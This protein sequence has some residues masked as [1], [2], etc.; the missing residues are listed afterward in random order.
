MKTPILLAGVRQAARFV[1]AGLLAVLIALIIGYLMVL[2]RRPEL[3]PWHTAKLSAEFRSGDLRTVPDLNAY[4]A[5]EEELFRQLKSEVYDQI[6][7]EDRRAFNR[8]SSGSL[9]DPAV[10]A[11]NW[12]RTFILPAASPRG[13]VLLLHGLSDAPYSLRALGQALH[14]D[15]FHVIGLRLPGHGTAP[16]GLTRARAEDFSAATRIAAVALRE[17]VGTNVPLFIIGYSN[18]ATLAVDYALSRM[19]GEPLPQVDG[20]ILISPAI[21]ITP[22]AVAAGWLRRLSQLPGMKKAAWQ[23][24]GLEYE[25][26]KY[27]SFAVNA[28]E[29]IHRLT[30]RL[31]QRL[32]RLDQGTGVAGFPPVLAFQSVVDSTVVPTAVIDRLLRRLAPDEHELVLFDIHRGADVR[33]LMVS[34]PELFTETLMRDAT[35][36]FAVSAVTSDLSEPRSVRLLRR[37]AGKTEIDSQPLGL[38]WPSGVF[39]LSHVALPF[40]PD[41]PVYGNGSGAKTNQIALGHLEVRGEGGV[42]AIP[43]RVLLRLR[44]NPFYSYLEQRVREFCGASVR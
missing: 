12:N 22:G 14:R 43:P 16:V 28:S 19:E 9:A 44:Y 1:L 33:S 41:D 42:L 3:K 8:F 38:Q 25:P 10:L 20:L 24:V 15:G 11:T 7:D 18:G 21:G 31:Y 6:E 26:Y 34:T 29:Q 39:S 30:T 2:H 4:L 17:A 40:P 32:Q 23:S 37:A 36:P 35:T 13:G 5:R 27:N